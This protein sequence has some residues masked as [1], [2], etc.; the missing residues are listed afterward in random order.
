MG[1]PLPCVGFAK[2]VVT[3][4]DKDFA[5]LQRPDYTVKALETEK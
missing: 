1:C 4:K 2:K 5:V 3:S